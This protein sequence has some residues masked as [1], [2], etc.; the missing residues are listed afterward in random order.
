MAHI[1]TV[2]RPLGLNGQYRRALV[3]CL[4]PF[5]AVDGLYQKKSY[6]V[7]LGF[8]QRYLGYPHCTLNARVFH[9]PSLLL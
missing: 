4:V 9:A 6:I 8:R 2:S 5:H 1:G 3:D 7:L